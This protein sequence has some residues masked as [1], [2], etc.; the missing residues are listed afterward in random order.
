MTQP[1]LLAQ[2]PLR[3]VSKFLLLVVLALTQLSPALHAQDKQD[4]TASEQGLRKLEKEWDN[5]IVSRD[6]TL[7][8][9][10]LNDDFQYIDSAGDVH[11]KSDII[12]G[13]KSSTATIEP[14]E[15]EDVQTRIYGTTGILTGRFTQ[16]VTYEGKTYS[17]QFRYTDVYVKQ[18]GS[19]RAVSAHASRIPDA[20][21]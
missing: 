16:K 20:T 15:T 21:K 6:L 18:E 9:R 1:R 8:D 17:G 11:S 13:V 2:T 3:S 5:A 14:F 10:I 12:Q 7:L 19:W 4:E